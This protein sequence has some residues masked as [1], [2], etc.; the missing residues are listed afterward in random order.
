MSF[1]NLK[2]LSGSLNIIISVLFLFWWGMMGAIIISSGN[3]NISTLALVRLPGYQLQSVVGL[4]ACIL[5]PIGIIGLY[6]PHAE[7]VGKLGLAGS[8]L[9]SLGV[10]L[11]GCMQ[12]DETF[13]WPVLAVKAPVLLGAGGLMSDP[14]FLFIYFFMGIVL[15]LGFI[16]FGIAFWRARV[17]PRWSVLFFSAGAL[18]FGI[19]MAVMIRT[20][21]LALWV[22]GWGWMGYL[23]QREKTA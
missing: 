3:F 7:K 2:R 6:L 9:G 20:I 17:F 23:L 14:A 22:V 12:F 4:L 10:I 18:L 11:Y 16:L 19:G 13:T 8:L 5:A 15:A 1:S 21:G